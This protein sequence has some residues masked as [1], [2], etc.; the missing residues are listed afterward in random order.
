MLSPCNHYRVPG[1]PI[2]GALDPWRT[3]SDMWHSAS[4]YALI[5]SNEDMWSGSLAREIDEGHLFICILHSV[6]YFNSK[7]TETD[8]KTN[9]NR[10][11]WKLTYFLKKKIP[12]AGIFQK[13]NL[14]GSFIIATKLSGWDML[15]ETFR[16]VLMLT[17]HTYIKNKSHVKM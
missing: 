11:V 9:K 8:W 2:L 17:S 10:N 7:L 4:N 13:K 12:N 3:V 1:M 15:P 14:T 5:D 16:L 6:I